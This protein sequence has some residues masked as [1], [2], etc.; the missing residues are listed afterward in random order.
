[1]ITILITGGAGNVASSLAHKLAENKTYTIIIADNLLT[2]STAKIPL[3][4]NVV[5]YH[6]DV[7]NYES[8][9]KVFTENTIDY[10]FHYAAVVGVQRT[11]DNPLMVFRDIDGIRNILELSKDYGVKRVFYSSS[12]EVYGEPFEI[13]QN[14]KT[15]PLNSRLPYAIVKNLG[16]AMFK[17]YQK[18]FNLPYTIFR[19]FNTYGPNQS[20]DFV[21]PR[22]INMALTNKPITTYGDGS[23]TRTFCYIDDNIDAC[24]RI[25]EENLFINDVINIGNDNE[26]TIKELAELVIKITGSTAGI[27]Q[28][29]ALEDG[30]MSRRCPDI[31]KMR[32]ILNRDFIN[33]E[34]GIKNLIVFYAHRK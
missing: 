26:I 27:K 22:F 20:D 19:F 1:M 17:A 13:P 31:S 16:E 14:E 15:T 28:L 29:P 32:T 3:A 23:Q 2:G 18:E 24:I 33:L 4:D 7:N 6:I 25:F 30:D 11:L 10:V 5:F 34:T 8:I 12:S 21:V 9:R